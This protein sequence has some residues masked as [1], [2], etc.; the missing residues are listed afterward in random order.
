M[1]RA[2]QETVDVVG[3]S[4]ATR[5]H[6]LPLRQGRVGRRSCA[7]RPSGRGPWP[8]STSRG[9]LGFGEDDL[10]WLGP[11][12]APRGDRRRRACSARPS[13]RT[14]RRCS[15][16]C[17]PGAWPTPSS[18][19]GCRIYEHTE[20]LADRH[21]PG[22]RPPSVVHQRRHRAGRVRGAR[23]RGLD[24]RPCPGWSAPSSRCTP[25]WWPP[26]PSAPTS[27]RGP[28]WTERA[29]FADHRHMIIYG[30]RTADDRIAFGGRGAPYH[31]GSAVR[32]SF[33]SEPARARAC[34][35]RPW[36][37]SS[38][39]W[40]T[41]ASPTPGA[42]RSASRG[43]GTPRSASTAPPAWPG[44]AATWATGSPPPTWPAARWPTSSP[45]RHA[46]DPTSPGSGT[47]S[48]RWEP[49]PLRWLGVNAGL[50]T[51]K[52]AD[53]SEARHGRPSRVAGAMGRLLGQ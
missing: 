46:A 36:P 40:P 13:R 18:A 48:P 49:E 1:R 8:R 6:R 53:R 35:A 26:S 39:S 33:D 41:P 31:F 51:M 43:T 24:G 25:S 19:A 47:V 50:W 5:G 30:Q 29:T 37:S 9:P 3:A 38:R 17:W 20:V 32:P 11:D 21:G 7:A 14:A 15:R 12:E 16:R 10:R 45:G 28:D 44:P 27:G 23:H 4:A 34:C 52:L 42:G 2:M 22:G